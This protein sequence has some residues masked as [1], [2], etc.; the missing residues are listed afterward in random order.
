MALKFPP[1]ITLFPTL[2]IGLRINRG[3]LIIKFIKSSR[4]KL[5]WSRFKDLNEGLLQE[6]ISEIGAKVVSNSS[7][8]VENGSLK[9]SRSMKGIL[10]WERNSLPLRQPCHLGHQ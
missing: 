10:F 7:S 3:S 4:V 1:I 8:S 9:K 5:P 6:K 2:R